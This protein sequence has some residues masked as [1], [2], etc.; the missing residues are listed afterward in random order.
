ML[1]EA[2]R[3]R[4]LL[5][6]EEAVHML[7]EVPANLY[8]LVDRGA[9]KEGHYA[10]VIVIDENAIGSQPTSIVNDLP[11]EAPRLFAGADGVE[12]VF[13]NGKEIVSS[14]EFTSSRPGS[15]LKS[16]TH[17]SNPQWFDFLISTFTLPL[18]SE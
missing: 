1:G 15:V 7:T 5:E 9:I 14:G 6:M 18:N 11:L 12:H 17:T 4:A 13:C 16:G 10:D 3:K 2:V 8:G